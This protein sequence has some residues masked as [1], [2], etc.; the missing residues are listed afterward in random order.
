M[1]F[2][3]RV[4]FIGCPWLLIIKGFQVENSLKLVSTAKISSGVW[5]KVIWVVIVFERY[6]LSLL[7]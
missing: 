1:V 2:S 5:G 7:I 6:L 4:P 3:S